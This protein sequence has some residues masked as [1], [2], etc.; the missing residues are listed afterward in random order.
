M[1]KM[2]ALIGTEDVVLFMKGT[3]EAPR[4]GFSASVVEILEGLGAKYRTVD[5]LA[6]PEVREGIK[7]YSDWP[8]IPQL[9]IKGEFVGGAD[10]AQELFASGEL[11]K[12]LGVTAAAPACQVTLTPAAAK[13]LAGAQDGEPADARFL[14]VA[15]SAR[16]QHQLGFSQKNAGDVA[17]ASEGLD[18]VVDAGS[19]RRA[20]GIVIDA[21]KQGDGVAFRITNPNEPPMVK[22]MNVQELKQRL[23]DAK[24]EGKRVELFDARTPGERAKAAI[25][26]SK[27][28]DDEGRAYLEALPKETP[29]V[30]HCHHGGRSQAAAEHF[31][32]QGFKT[33]YNVT[34]GIDAWSAEVDPTVP[35]Y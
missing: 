23:D 22:P 31:L 4:C 24:R 8:T 5:V 17:C 1:D 10:I 9:Y 29:V 25:E 19:A 3:R 34:G 32:K 30:F 26:G 33:V 11:Q 21:V 13:V 27:L 2:E 6:D 18:I 20:N 35:R 12:K 14:R 15:V 16:F 7:A 28:L